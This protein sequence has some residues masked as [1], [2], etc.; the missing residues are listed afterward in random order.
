MKKKLE[1]P[2]LP[3]VRWETQLCFKRVR[4][5]LLAGVLK[6]IVNA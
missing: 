4:D 3:G 5:R 2:R 1:Y 6:W